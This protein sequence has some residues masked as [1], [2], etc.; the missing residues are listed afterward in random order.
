MWLSWGYLDPG[1]SA[2]PYPLPGASYTYSDAENAEVMKLVP[3]AEQ[4]DTS[5]A[6]SSLGEWF[7]PWGEEALVVATNVL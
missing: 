7:L 6:C 2:V 5:S 1:C 4:L 3:A